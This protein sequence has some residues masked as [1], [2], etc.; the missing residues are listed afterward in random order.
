[1]HLKRSHSRHLGEVLKGLLGRKEKTVR[2]FGTRLFGKP[3]EVLSQ[4]P[5]SGKSL[6][7]AAHRKL[8]GLPSIH[9]R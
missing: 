2:E 5:L 1:M 8:A 6:V 3:N 7:D 9:N 4:I